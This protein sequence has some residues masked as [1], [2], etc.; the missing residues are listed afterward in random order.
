MLAVLVIA[1]QLADSFLLRPHIAEQTADTGLVVPWIVALLGYS[2]YG[3]GGAVFGTIYAVFA[4]AVLDQLDRENR[5][6]TSSPF[7]RRPTRTPLRGETAVEALLDERT[8]LALVDAQ[9]GLGEELDAV[10]DLAAVTE[11]IEGGPEGRL[12]LGVAGTH[13]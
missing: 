11:G 12:V 1:G 6:R 7:C 8:Q 10:D 13:R 3:I 4:L 5:R 2:I 9:E